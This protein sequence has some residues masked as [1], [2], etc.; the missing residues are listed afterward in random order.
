MS[1]IH[2]ILSKAERDG[3]AR[4]MRA[5]PAA[6]AEAAVA[7]PLPAPIDGEP[8]LHDDASAFRVSPVAVRDSEPARPYAA[9]HYGAV[10]TPADARAI[11]GAQLDPLLVAGLAPQSL[12]AEQ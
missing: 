4:R 8:R 11:E 10:A 12:A 1:R 6:E 3:T 9:G 2:D 7:P 5:V